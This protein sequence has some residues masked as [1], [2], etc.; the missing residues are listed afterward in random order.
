ML[1]ILRMIYVEKKC[2][3][4]ADEYMYLP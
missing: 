2:R 3:I 1:I 4:L